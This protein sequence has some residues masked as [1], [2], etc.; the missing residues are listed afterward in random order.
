[1]SEPFPLWGPGQTSAAPWTHRTSAHVAASA[2]SEVLRKG[3]RSAF[4]RSLGM[5]L[6]GIEKVYILEAPSPTFGPACKHGYTRVE[7]QHT[8]PSL[9]P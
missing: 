1:M 4:C 8:A 7:M 6:L 5:V 3:L 2:G 9:N